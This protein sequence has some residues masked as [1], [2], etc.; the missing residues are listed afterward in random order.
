TLGDHSMIARLWADEF[1][2]IARGLSGPADAT[3]IA[4]RVIKTISDPVLIEGRAVY[5]A[6]SVGAALYPDHGHDVASLIRAADIALHRSKDTGRG[7]LTL[8]RNEL[9]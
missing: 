6:C 1:A 7:R 3:L 2:F 9:S 8:Y 5:P 4:S